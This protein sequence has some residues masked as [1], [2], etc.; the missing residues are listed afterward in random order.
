MR[1]GEKEIVYLSYCLCMQHAKMRNTLVI[2]YN[3]LIYLN[4]YYSLT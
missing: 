3:I 2:K 1:K 4:L